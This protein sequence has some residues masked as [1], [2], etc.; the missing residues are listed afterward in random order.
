MN[1]MDESSKDILRN[2]GLP[3]LSPP[4]V[5]YFDQVLIGCSASSGAIVP[6]CEL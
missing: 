1:K 6:L 4:V 5:T 3:L 2:R